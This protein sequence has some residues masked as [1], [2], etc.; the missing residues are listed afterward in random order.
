MAEQE[1]EQKQPQKQQDE[2]ELSGW[3]KFEKFVETHPKTIFW[4]RFF[5]WTV[6]ACVLPFLFIVFRFNLFQTISKMRFGGWGIIAVIIVAFFAIAIL[7]YVKI[8]LN[9]KYSMTAQLLNGFCK[10]IIPLLTVYLIVYGF[11]D[12]IGMLLQVMGVVIIC[13]AIAIPINP[14]PKWAYEKQ[15]DVR[16]EERKEAFDYLI[17][18]F[19]RRKKEEETHGGD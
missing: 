7:K 10:V 15:K 14:L 18:S 4:I 16:V 17:D 2:P 5:F 19:F 1:L 12:D 3:E 9:A 6:F 11:R 13:E 8:A